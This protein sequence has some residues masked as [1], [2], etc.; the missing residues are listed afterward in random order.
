MI[1]TCWQWFSIEYINNAIEELLGPKLMIPLAW[2]GTCIYITYK[3]SCNIDVVGLPITLFIQQHL[4]T[5]KNPEPQDD[6]GL[7]S[8]R[9]G[10]IFCFIFN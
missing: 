2:V 6:L 5:C 9:V 3:L 8:L 7:S 1:P 10:V 4:Q